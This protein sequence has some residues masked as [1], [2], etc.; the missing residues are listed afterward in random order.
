L[1]PLLFLKHY[2]YFDIY[3]ILCRLFQDEKPGEARG[4]LLPSQGAAVS[5]FQAEK[6]CHL[7]Q[8]AGAARSALQAALGLRGLREAGGVFSLDS[9]RFMGGEV[10][11]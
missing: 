11:G 1:L 2:I 6:F 9:L 4:P 8:G 3:Y 10:S 5:L 7:L